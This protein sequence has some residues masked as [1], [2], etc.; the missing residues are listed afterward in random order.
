M[1]DSRPIKTMEKIAAIVSGAIIASAVIY[2]TIQVIGVFEFLEM[3][4]G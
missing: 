2:W 1:T 4:Y 3:A